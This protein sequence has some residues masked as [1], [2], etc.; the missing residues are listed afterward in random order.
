[1]NFTGLYKAIVQSYTVLN[2]LYIKSTYHEQPH[3]D[4][5]PENQA[6]QQVQQDL[7]CKSEKKD[8]DVYTVY[9]HI[10]LIKDEV[11]KT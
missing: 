9:N 11:I 5:R 8:R 3:N 10:Y 2:S 4:P 6:D 7:V 1:M